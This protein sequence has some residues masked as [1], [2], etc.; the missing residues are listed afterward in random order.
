MSFCNIIQENSQQDLMVYWFLNIEINSGIEEKNNFLFCLIVLTIFEWGAFIKHEWKLWWVSITNSRA[1]IFTVFTA[2]LVC[3][4]RSFKV[5][6][7]H[8][9]GKQRK[10]RQNKENKSIIHWLVAEKWE[11]LKINFEKEINAYWSQATLILNENIR[12][13]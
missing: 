5:S 6:V 8:F 10:K 3:S 11:F 1:F 9:M 4:G 13:S 12:Y 7:V 2:G